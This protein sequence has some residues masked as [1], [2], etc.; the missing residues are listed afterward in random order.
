MRKLFCFFFLLTV[1]TLLIKAQLPVGSWRDHLCYTNVKKVLS[2]D[3]KIYC[4]TEQNL[5]IYNTLDNSF[6]KMSTV[7]GLSDVG[8]ANIAYYK[9]KDIFL[10]SYTNGNLDLIHANKITNIP[11]L[12]RKLLTASKGAN[13]ILFN[14]D[15]AYCC[16]DFGILVIDLLKNEIK[17]TYIIG[18][19]GATYAVNSLVI[20]GD[21]FYAA[22]TR[23][24]FKAL[25]SDPYLIDFSRW[26]KQ[27]SIS[28][29]DRKFGSI[30]SFQNQLIVNSIGDNSA[31]DTLYQ[32]VNTSWKKIDNTGYSQINELTATDKYLV[33]TYAGKV[34][35]LDQKFQKVYQYAQYAPLS[36]LT[37]NTNIWIGDNSNGLIKQ[38]LD[39]SQL[40]FYYPQ[41]PATNSLWNIRA[42]N[43][44]ILVTAGSVGGSWQEKNYPG[45]V[46]K[47]QDETWYNMW[48]SGT[49]YISVCGDPDDPDQFYVG[50]WGHGV[51]VYK[52]NEPIENYTDKNST[53]QD[54]IQGRPYM[55]IGGIAFD[56]D[57]NMWLTNSGVPSPIS[58]RIK[59]SND[60]FKW[61]SYNYNL[62]TDFTLGDIITDINGNFWVVLPR[63][64]G[65]FA[66]NINGTINDASDDVTL[67]FKPMDA[68]GKIIDNVLCIAN[69]RDGS[70]WV[71]TERG[72]IV[73]TDP[74]AIFNNGTAGYQPTIPRNDG[75]TNADA[76]LGGESVYCIAVD[77]A[78]RKWFGTEDGG[79]FLISADGTKQ[80][81]N[82]NTS[83]SP[84]YSNFVRSIAIQPKTGEVFFGTDKGI[85]SYR[86]LATEPEG[87]LSKAY[88]FPNPV[89]PEY[90]G[91]I[92]ITNLVENTSV[93]ITDISGNLVYQTSSQGGSA[94]WDGK[95]RKGNRAATGVYLIFLTN[96]DGLLTNVIKLLMVR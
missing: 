56:N 47:F 73:Y 51:F 83:N 81:L 69:D 65:L 71:G 63:G 4:A 84:L 40:S 77:G 25:V 74:S 95:N 49:D 30:V 39:G 12:K 16:C 26:Q 45:M 15:Y 28:L 22:T 11:D 96:E 35:V 32:L 44:S 27:T 86:G 94:T 10:I 90:S 55:R 8:V 54:I 66:F 42:H 7:T 79:A 48:G 72:P 50:S 17:D 80:I 43:N 87:D 46:Y 3:T 52:N 37:D 92:T 75:T 5:F 1:W 58:V 21:Y 62:S 61:K 6:Q 93:K 18:E 67:T 60:N 68:Y 89:R 59:G 88:A 36:A 34:Q 13:H 14:G 91:N 29:P 41:G 70:V 9:D 38:P 57:R 2:V 31:S 53:I 24:I 64:A 82:F 78:N 20:V 85:I 33:I 19:L 23:G 76:L